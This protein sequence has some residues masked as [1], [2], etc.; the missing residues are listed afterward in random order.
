MAILRQVTAKFRVVFFRSVNALVCEAV[1]SGPIGT[2]R[3]RSSFRVIRA[4][5]VRAADNAVGHNCGAGGVRLEE[6]QYLLTNGG[7]TADVQVALG[8]P[9]FEKIRLVIFGEDHAHH[10]LGG[11]RVVRSVEGHGSNRVAAKTRTEFVAQSRL[12]VWP[13]SGKPFPF[14]HQ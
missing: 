1:A 8:E 13:L 10:N 12:G 6:G 9:A 7:I 4:F 2:L 11:Q 3:A 5:F 14:L